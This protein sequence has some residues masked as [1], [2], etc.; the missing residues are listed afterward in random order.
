MVY[1]PRPIPVASTDDHSVSATA[2]TTAPG[3]GA[4]LATLTTPPRGIY[5]V[6]AEV[7]LAAGTPA[8]AEDINVEI[9]RAAVQQKRM[10]LGRTVGGEHTAECVIEVDGAQN[11]SL[12]AVAAATAGVVYLASLTATKIN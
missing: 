1:D 3:A 5:R 2:S 10:V 12:N 9:R 7:V 4:A 8:A 11:I 6:R